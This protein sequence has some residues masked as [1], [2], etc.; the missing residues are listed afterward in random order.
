MTFREKLFNVLGTTMAVGLFWTAGQPGIA[1]TFRGAWHYGAHFGTF[2]LFGA[3]W[4]LGLPRIAP[5]AIAA[6]VVTFGFFHEAYEIAGHAHAFELADAVVDGLGAGFGI[7]CF[8]P[9]RASSP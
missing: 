7:L 6:G 1:E 5:P 3:M 8:G 9:R 2:A 4:R